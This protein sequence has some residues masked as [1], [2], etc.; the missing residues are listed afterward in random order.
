MLKKLIRNVLTSRM[1]YVSIKSDL[2]SK[3]KISRFCKVKN[4]K[5]GRYSYIGPSSVINNC[6]IGNYCSISSNV[7]IGLGTH[8]INFLSSS[9]LFY[10]KNN[11]FGESEYVHLKFN[12]EIKETRIGNDVWIGANVLI[13][14]GVDIGNGSIIAAGSVVTKDVKDFTVVGGVPAKFIKE[15]FDLEKV[16]EIEKS[17]WWDFNPEIA[18]IISK[19]IMGDENCN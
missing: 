14:D 4:S 5:I 19:E 17:K 2:N 7:K 16:K 8:P 12:D 18:V 3:S 10:S 11:I 6:L 15:R 9:P 13:L 1:M